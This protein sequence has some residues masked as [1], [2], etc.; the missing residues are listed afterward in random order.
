MQNDYLS[1]KLAAANASL[2]GQKEHFREA[3]EELQK[4]LQ[5]TIAGRQQLLSMKERDIHEQEEM[6]SR[7]QVS[8]SS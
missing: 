3:I 7:L 4:K 6:I 2:D 1:K 5:E 8:T